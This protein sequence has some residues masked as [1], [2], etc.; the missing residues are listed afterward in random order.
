MSKRIRKKKHLRK[1]IDLVS[2]LKEEQAII[3]TQGSF[4]KVKVQT[5]VLP[6]GDKADQFIQMNGYLIEV[7]RK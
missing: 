4:M 3:L 5:I 7:I 2:N 1:V 6:W